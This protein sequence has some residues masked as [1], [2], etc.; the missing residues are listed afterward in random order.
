MID[1]NEIPD[2][3]ESALKLIEGLK[4]EIRR[5]PKFL[6]IDLQNELSA[7]GADRL[8]TFIAGRSG[9]LIELETDRGRFVFQSCVLIETPD[10]V[11]DVIVERDNMG[12][13]LIVPTCIQPNEL[14]RSE[15]V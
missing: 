8:H 2:T 7:I 13:V 3:L 9:Y 14:S 1:L 10:E 6:A 5:R 12:N 15:V 11:V 4:D